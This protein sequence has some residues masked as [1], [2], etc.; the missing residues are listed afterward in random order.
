VSNERLKKAS[1][2]K[3]GVKSVAEGWPLVVAELREKRLGKKRAA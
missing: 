1:G 2:W 3:P